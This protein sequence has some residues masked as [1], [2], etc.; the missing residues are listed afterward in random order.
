MSAYPIKLCSRRSIRDTIWLPISSAELRLSSIGWLRRLAW[1]LCTKLGLQFDR[2]IVDEHYETFEINVQ[3]LQ[4]L[5][6]HNQRDMNLIWNRRAKYIVVGHKTLQQ[7]WG[8]LASES[9]SSFDARLHLGFNGH[10]EFRGMRIVTVPWLLEGVL[11]LPDLEEA[12]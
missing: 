8:E 7:L 5:I 9:F 4:D 10:S 2:P 1:Y 12:Q 11:L 6:S 3:S